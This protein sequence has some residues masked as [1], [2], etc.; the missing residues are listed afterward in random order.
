MGAGLGG[1]LGRAAAGGVAV[2][3][4]VSKDK[5]TVMSDEKEKQ[6]PTCHDCGAREGELH[7]F[8]CDMERCPFCGGQLIGCG[9]EYKILG[10]KYYG[11]MSHHST[12]GLPKDVFYDGL[13][14]EEWRVFRWV[15]DQRGR[16]PYI[17]YPVLCARC[18]KLWPDFFKVPDEEWEYYVEPEKRNEV[19]CR[20]C[21]D[22]V[23]QV[24]DARSGPMESP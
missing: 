16:I 12:S 2:G 4:V 11:P 14:D 10:Y 18:G 17:Q 9:C 22:Y 15:L 8:G 24:T 3:G 13:P 20:E 7:Q 23:K 21:Y 19:L 1:E 5:E 6:G